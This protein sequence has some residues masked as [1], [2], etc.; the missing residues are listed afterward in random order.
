MQRKLVW[1]KYAAIANRTKQDFCTHRISGTSHREAVYVMCVTR[2]DATSAKKKR[3]SMIFRPVLGM[4][5][6]V[7]RIWFAT[8]AFVGRGKSASG[9]A[10]TS[11]ANKES[12]WM[13]SAS[14]LN[15]VRTKGRKWLVTPE[16][17]TRACRDSKKNRRKYLN[18]VLHTSRKN[19][20]NEG[21][22]FEI[23]LCF[24]VIRWR[25]EDFHLVY[26]LH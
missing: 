2:S 15:Y 23:Y 8:A 1:R 11:D 5:H 12:L 22:S 17:A 26:G 21:A 18:A 20:G 13:S 14:Q 3:A 19:Q 24:R 25:Y 4:S 10:K 9:L 16:S 6:V 7:L